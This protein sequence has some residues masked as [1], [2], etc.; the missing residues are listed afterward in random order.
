MRNCTPHTDRSIPAM[1]DPKERGEAAL[2]YFEQMTP[3]RHRLAYAQIFHTYLSNLEHGH[4]QQVE[5]CRNQM[6]TLLTFGK[7]SE[8]DRRAIEAKTCRLRAEARQLKSEAEKIYRGQPPI[9]L[10]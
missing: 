10:H 7:I 1:S 8:A 9:T 3:E 4:A 5:A 2:K 6:A